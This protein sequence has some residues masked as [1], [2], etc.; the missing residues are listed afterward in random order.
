M[1]NQFV[2]ITYRQFFDRETVK[3]ATDRYERKVLTK[4][5]AFG[6]TVMRRSFRRTSTVSAPGRPPHSHVGLLRDLTY[7]AYDQQ[8]GS[9]VVGPILFKRKKGTSKTLPELLDQG[10]V[11]SENGE[12]KTYRARPFVDPAL[13]AAANEMQQIQRDALK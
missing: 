12:T 5:G 10:G 9:V 3:R 6:R 13:T 7:F 2:N 8:A 4:T 1:A 11:V